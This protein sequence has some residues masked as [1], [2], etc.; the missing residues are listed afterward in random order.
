MT[1][2]PVLILGAGGHARVLI[3]ALRL[4]GRPITG[5][6]DADRSLTGA[7]VMGISVIGTDEAV[8]GFRPEEVRLVNGIGSVASTLKRKEIFGDFQ[9]RGYHFANV[10]HPSA[11]VASDAQLGE[12]AQVMAGAVIQ[13]GVRLGKLHHQY[14]RLPGP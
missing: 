5:I 13:V 11:V 3:D 14:S 7:R 6:V 8:L 2:L 1:M 4:T 10:V 12:G 9:K